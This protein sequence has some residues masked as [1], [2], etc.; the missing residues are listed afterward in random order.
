[1]ARSYFIL[2]V[3]SPFVLTTAQA[4]WFAGVGIADSTGSAGEIRTVSA[5]SRLLLSIIQLSIIINII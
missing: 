1:M 5:A 2:L 3:L 4:V